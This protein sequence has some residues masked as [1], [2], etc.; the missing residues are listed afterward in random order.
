MIKATVITL[1]LAGALYV[2]FIRTR[3]NTAFNGPNMGAVAGAYQRLALAT[4]VFVIFWLPL[5]SISESLVFVESLSAIR[6]LQQY[7]NWIVP[8]LTLTFGW[9]V[10]AKS[11]R[12]PADL[13][14]LTLRG[15]AVT[16]IV[17]FTLFALSGPLLFPTKPNQGAFVGLFQIGPA[18]AILGGLGGCFLWSIRQ[19]HE[20]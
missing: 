5:G 11:K 15:V 14:S 1:L 16:G 7:A 8:A 10:W 12:A 3:L 9:F 20:R 19:E 13:V 17:A 6:Y 4:A 2:F 18:L